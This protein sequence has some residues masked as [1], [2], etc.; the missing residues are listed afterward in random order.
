[1]AEEEEG[2][3]KYFF[4]TADG[5]E[6]PSSRDYSGFATATYPDGEIYEGYFVEGI[7]EGNGTYRYKDG[8]VYTGE[9]KKNVKHGYGTL[10]YSKFGEYKGFWENGRRHGEGVFTYN[11]NGDTYSGW[12]RF[13]QKEGSGTYTFK[14]SGMKIV[15][16]WKEGVVNQG[17]WVYP[18]GMF[19][20]GPFENNK[21]SGDGEW[22]FPYN[23]NSCKGTHSQKKL[24]D[25][26]E[27]DPD[28]PP[29][30]ARFDITWTSK[31]DIAESSQGINAIER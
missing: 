4:V 21:P 14:E 20:E 10:N 24:E 27:P 5:E 25:E 2:G 11:A 13:G 17:K 8:D 16:E 6:K 12:W 7:R 23:N 1:M 9:W 22:N 29:P 18:N 26:E 30:K 31:L 3:P 28:L 19:Y 15:G